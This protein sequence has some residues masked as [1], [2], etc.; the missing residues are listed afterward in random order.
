MLFFF[1][2]GKSAFF[3]ESECFWTLNPYPSP[4]RRYTLSV[5]LKIDKLR[6][7]AR[8]TNIECFNLMSASAERREITPQ[9]FAAWVPTQERTVAACPI[10]TRVV[11][12][13]PPASAF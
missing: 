2:E 10:R 12:S 9:L 6:M 13:C 5:F 7:D 3:I 4:D 11:F 1:F 8:D